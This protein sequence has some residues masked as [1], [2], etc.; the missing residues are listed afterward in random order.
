MGSPNRGLHGLRTPTIT[1]DPGYRA[2]LEVLMG[3]WGDSVEEEPHALALESS[4]ADGGYVV[5]LNSFLIPCAFY[6]IGAKSIRFGSRRKRRK[7]G[8]Q[9]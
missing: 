8:N 7:G 3:G 2:L 9:E 4:Q 6:R 1:N 5:I